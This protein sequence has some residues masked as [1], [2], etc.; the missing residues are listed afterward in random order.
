MAATANVTV[1]FPCEDAADA[2]RL[3]AGW[4]LHEG[5]QVIASV[6]ENLSPHGPHEATKAGKLKAAEEP[7]YDSD[8]G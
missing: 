8:A 3:I 1:T 2:E 4:K 7:T 5:V 6:T